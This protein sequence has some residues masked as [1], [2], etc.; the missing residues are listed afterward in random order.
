MIGTWKGSV[1]IPTTSLEDEEKNL[2]GEDKAGFLR[3]MR[4]ML[5]WKPEERPTASEL[6]EDPWLS[7]YD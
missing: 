1:E 6:T 5:R 3:Y 4:R 7:A 2:E